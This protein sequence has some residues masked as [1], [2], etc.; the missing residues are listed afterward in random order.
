MSTTPTPAPTPAPTPVP[1]PGSFQI[2]TQLATVLGLICGAATVLNQTTFGFPLA[3]QTTITVA[4]GA[5][6]FLAIGPILGP[7]FRAALHLPGWLATVIGVV[8]VVLMVVTQQNASLPYRAIV[9]GVIQVAGSLGFDPVPVPTAY[10][11]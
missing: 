5:F 8:L 4:L 1:K 10:L 6:G 7:K 2:P 3:V 9:I 11:I